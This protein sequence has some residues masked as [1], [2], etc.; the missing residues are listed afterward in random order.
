M[1]E[2]SRRALLRAERRR[3]RRG[4][5]R[6]D[7][8]G[9]RGPAPRPSTRAPASCGSATAVSGSSTR[10]GR[11]RM[12]LT[13]VEDLHGAARRDNH[14]FA[15]TFRCATAG[16]PQGTYTFRRPG[17]H[18]DD[19]VRG[20]K[21]CEPTDLPGDHQPLVTLRTG[22]LDLDLA[23]HD[24]IERV[25]LADIGQQAGRLTSVDHR[26]V[27]PVGDAVVLGDDVVEA[28]LPIDDVGPSAGIDG[29]V[30]L[31]AGDPVVTGPG[32]DQ[33]VAGVAVELVDARPAIDA[34]VAAAALGMVVAGTAG[35][36]SLPS[37]PCSQSSP[38]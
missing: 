24:D 36:Q 19:A 1:T 30:A 13:Q 28:L 26:A 9:R 37:L 17:L 27:E 31:V 2:T 33:V 12:T 38:S 11:W 29:V 7:R 14:R 21:R 8:D 5:L 22:L 34:V 3:S 15:L 16:P 32:E 20:A 23:Q 35:D 4:A 6:L 25:L 18:P 10:T